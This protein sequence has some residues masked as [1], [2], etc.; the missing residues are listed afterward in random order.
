MA[1]FGA[2]HPTRVVILEAKPD[3]LDPGVDARVTVYG[4]EVGLHPVSF[5]EIALQVRAAGC[6]HLDSIIEP[7]TL[8]DLPLVLW[9]PSSLPEVSDCLLPV[10]DTVVVDSREAGEL[11]TLASLVDLARRRVAVDLSWERLAPW[12]ELLAGLFDSPMYRP[13]ASAV[14][15][16]D[17]EGKPGPRRLLA[18]WLLSRL[19]Q[20]EPV[21]HLA[22]ARHVA[23]RLHARHQGRAGTFEVVR[24]EGERVVRASAVVDGGPSHTEVL[25]L[26][27]NSLVWSLSRALTHLRRD[28]TWEQALS[29]AVG[30]GG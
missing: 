15:S 13:F 20:P 17:V 29:G 5:E 9:Y 10:A 8:S 25:A 27:G 21:V 12:R 11:E 18:G 14:S 1:D 7:F 16:I 23:I 30:I 28:R 3:A 24:S 26:P 19:G 4:D 2:H 6:A 22:D